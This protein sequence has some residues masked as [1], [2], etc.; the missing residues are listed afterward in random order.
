MLPLT[1]FP[2]PEH[3]AFLMRGGQPAV[4]LVHGFPGTPASIHPLADALARLGCTVSGLL[5]PGFGAQ[6]ETLPKRTY[7]EWLAAIRAELDRLC[8]EGH[9][10]ILLG[11]HSMGAA[12]S[13]QVAA[14][15][16]VP[17]NGLILIA[18][19]VRI[20]HP[21]WSLMPLLKR[22]F[23]EIRP[24]RLLK[25]DL[26]HPEVRSGIA[27]FIPE[28]DLSQPE[29]QSAIM[30]FR[31]PLSLFDQVRQ[32]GLQGAEAAPKVTLPCLIIQGTQD[33]LVKP[34]STR[35]LIRRYGGEISYHEVDAEHNLIRANTP[36]WKQIELALDSFLHKILTDKQG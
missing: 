30:D 18:P 7:P 21:L 33:A 3:E 27:N 16:D 25:L 17:L 2:G 15:S 36:Y 22:L 19:F 32:V 11:G 5:L 4:V 12:L 13:L 8:A 29:V 14:S 10:P 34:S 1:I 24:F 20:D 28:T 23:P 6:I 9:A 26:D 31:L 35:Q